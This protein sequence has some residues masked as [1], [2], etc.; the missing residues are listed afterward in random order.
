[1]RFLPGQF[2]TDL[3]AITL[4]RLELL[5]MRENMA[6]N[7]VHNLPPE[8]ASLVQLRG[9]LVRRINRLTNSTQE[10]THGQ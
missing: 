4:D 9:A 2:T 3:D 10:D 8:V 1:V 6:R 7:T 5:T